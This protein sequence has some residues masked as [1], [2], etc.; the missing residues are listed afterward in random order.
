MVKIA[1]C[2]SDGQQFELDGT[3]KRGIINP[4]DIGKWQINEIHWQTEARRLGWDIYTLEGNTQMAL[5]IYKHYGTKHWSW[6]EECW[7]KN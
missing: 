3:V 4:H 2:E 7:F 1:D 5:Y 6:S